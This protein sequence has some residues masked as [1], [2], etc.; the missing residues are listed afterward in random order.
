[1]YSKDPITNCELCGGRVRDSKENGYKLR[2]TYTTDLNYI[3]LN[4]IQYTVCHNCYV[5]THQFVNT[6]KK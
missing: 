2:T 5:K 4:K 1:M 3:V 6:L